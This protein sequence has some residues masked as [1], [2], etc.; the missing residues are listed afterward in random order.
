[1]LAPGATETGPAGVQLRLAGVPPQSAMDFRSSDASP[2]LCT[3]VVS[4]RG[5]PMT[6]VWK[7]SEAGSRVMAGPATLAA[8]PLMPRLTVGFAG[9]LLAMARQAPAGRAPAA[10][11]AKV[12]L[13]VALP[14][15]TTVNGTAGAQVTE[16]GVPG[17]DETP[18]TFSDAVP[19]FCTWVLS[20]FVLPTVTVWKLS[21]VGL[22]AIAGAAVFVAVPPTPRLTVGFAGSLLVM[23]RQAPA[24]RAPAAVGAKV[25]PRL[26]LPPGA[27]VNDAVGAQVTEPGVPGQDETR[28]TFSGAV[29]VFCT[30]VL[31]VFEVPTVTGWKLSEVGF[32]TMA[33]AGVFVAVPLRP[34]LR[35]GFA[36]SLLA[37]ARQ[38][39]AGRAPAA[40]G[41]KVTLRLALPPAATVNDAVGAHVT[42]PGVPGQG[43]TPVTFSGAVPVFCTWVL[44]VFALPTVTVWKS[45]AVGLRAIAGAEAADTANAGSATV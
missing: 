19:A 29:P 44:S 28:V 35:V 24:G 13:R 10:L 20:I 9:S 6:T 27:T 41:A 31:S 3:R 39:P 37:M 11:G 14:P 42:E 15:A 32:R 4:F 7:S 33:G 26:A 22:R 34:R 45:S 18:V 12:T 43:E 1:M 38:A 17:Q 23:A 2:A 36:G 8:V 30:W 40:V 5:A 25:T 16:P 21:E